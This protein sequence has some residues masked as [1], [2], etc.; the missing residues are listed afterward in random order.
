[1]DETTGY[2]SLAKVKFKAVGMSA[3]TD[4]AFEAKKQNAVMKQIISSII[5]VD[6]AVTNASMTTTSGGLWTDTTG[7]K[8]F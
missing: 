5:K 2:A 7:M 3:A 6:V 1:M 4:A 8:F